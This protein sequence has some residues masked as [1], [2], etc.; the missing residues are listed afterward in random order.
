MPTD[1]DGR[2]DADWEERV[3][4]LLGHVTMK[5]RSTCRASNTDMVQYTKLQLIS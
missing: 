4:G 5:Y 3:D 1:R 2:L